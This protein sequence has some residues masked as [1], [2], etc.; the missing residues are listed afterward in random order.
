MIPLGGELWV[1]EIRKG[2]GGWAIRFHHWIAPVKLFSDKP[3]GPYLNKSN[4]WNGLIVADLRGATAALIAKQYTNHRKEPECKTYV[5][6]V[7]LQDEAC[8]TQTPA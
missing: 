7:F 4:R 3:H 8:S 1:S 2:E 5:P 6:G